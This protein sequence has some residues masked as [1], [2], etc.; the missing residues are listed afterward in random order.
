[1]KDGKLV[2]WT[3]D[4][5][6]SVDIKSGESLMY[7]KGLGS[8]DPSDIAEVIKVD[9]LDTILK[10]VSLE[11][12]KFPEMLDAWLGDDSQKRKDMILANDFSIASI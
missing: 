9:G 1:M 8:L 12:P 6:G 7:F 10:P 4:I 5:E 3:F 11:D 2:R